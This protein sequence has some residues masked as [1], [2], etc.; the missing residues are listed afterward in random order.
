MQCLFFKT[1]SSNLPK[2]VEGEKTLIG[3]VFKMVVSEPPKS[4]PQATWGA[5]YLVWM[6]EFCWTFLQTLNDH[7][8]FA[9][10]GLAPYNCRHLSLK[11]FWSKSHFLLNIICIAVIRQMRSPVSH[12]TSS[13][14]KHIAWWIV[15]LIL[16]QSIL[17]VDFIL[18]VLK[19]RIYWPFVV[20]AVLTFKNR[21]WSFRFMIYF[22]C[23]MFMVE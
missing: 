1:K 17:P 2:Y 12:N 16:T 20:I 15:L 9:Q 8:T 23:R 5:N 4:K 6:R 19:F 7:Y 3:I 21:R 11:P 13:T 18:S 14:P 10:F 22:C